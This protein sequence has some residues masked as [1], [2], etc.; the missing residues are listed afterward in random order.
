MIEIWGTHCKLDYSEVSVYKRANGISGIRLLFEVLP[1]DKQ[2]KPK[3]K[4]L[5]KRRYG[6]VTDSSQYRA[7][8]EREGVTTIPAREVQ[9]RMSY[10]W[11]SVTHS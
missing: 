8:L 1:Q 3:T 5:T 6:P 7:T 11:N 10:C 9:Q 4:Q 2:R